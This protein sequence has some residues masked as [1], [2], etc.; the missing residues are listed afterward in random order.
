METTAQ[1]CAVTAPVQVTDA[2]AD[3]AWSALL[4]RN[5]EVRRQAQVYA[6]AGKPAAFI[7]RSGIKS[8]VSKDLESISGAWRVTTFGT[9]GQPWGHYGANNAFEAFREV[10]AGNPERIGRNH[11][12]EFV[13]RKELN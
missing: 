12:A 9:D 8:L 10:L 3:A 4:A 11:P 6:D 13:T 7:G 1:A 5:A 2:D